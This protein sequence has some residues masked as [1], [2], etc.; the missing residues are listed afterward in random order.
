[1]PRGGPTRRNVLASLALFCAAACSETRIPEGTRL[2]RPALIRLRPLRAEAAAVNVDTNQFSYVMEAFAY[3]LDSRS[4]EQ[5]A[6]AAA[7]AI[8]G[9]LK[10]R[11]AAMGFQVVEG[12]GGAAPDGPV[13]IIAGSITN[14]TEALPSQIST[15]DVGHPASQVNAR[16]RL[17]YQQA[18]GKPELW[19]RLDVAAPVTAPAAEEAEA[20]SPNAEGTPLAYVVPRTLPARTQE[21]AMQAKR[22]ADRLALRLHT[23]FAA[24]GWLA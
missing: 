8:T 6:K 4:R 5:D 3:P 24:Q 14:I 16:F 21:V 11:L 15:F 13:L 7:Q 22:L 19:Q 20:S 23:L 10:A 9:E 1:M 2:A 17:L 12:E 18:G